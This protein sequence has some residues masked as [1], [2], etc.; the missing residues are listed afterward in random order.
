MR[1]NLIFTRYTTDMQSMSSWVYFILPIFTIHILYTTFYSHS[2][3]H[4]QRVL[5]SIP[6]ILSILILTIIRAVIIIAF[7]T[8]PANFILDAI[9][10]FQLDASFLYLQNLPLKHN[11]ILALLLFAATISS[12]LP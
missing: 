8:S 9:L 6:I 3:H 11:I 5:Y 4:H 2:Q 7:P 12:L 1:P 10:R